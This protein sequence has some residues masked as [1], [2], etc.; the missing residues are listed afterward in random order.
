M[1]NSNVKFLNKEYSIPCD[2]VKYIEFVKF[3]NSISD[4]LNTIFKKEVVKNIEIIEDSD[5]MMNSITEET[6]KFISKLLEYDIYDKTVSD[7]LKSNKG[8]DLFL[9]TKKKALNQIISIRQEKL[10]AYKSGVEDAL[11]R[12]EAS[13]TGLDFGIL[14]NSFANAMLYAFMEASE[15]TKQEKAALKEYN[16]EISELEKGLKS[17]DRQEKDFII[18]NFIPAMQTVFAY[19]AY[20]LLDKFIADLV[21]AGKFEEDALK[22]VDLERSNDLL[23]NL[24]LAQNK[25]GVLEQAFVACPFNAA[26]YMNAMKYD[27]L[28]VDTF[29]TANYFGQSKT[30]ITFLEDNIGNAIYPDE[31]SIDFHCIDLLSK[32]TNQDSKELKRIHTIQFVEEIVDCYD[33]IKNKLNTPQFGEGILSKWD[34]ETISQ[35][36]KIS[37]G[38][39]E[40]Q[41]NAIVSSYIWDKLIDDCGH[42][43]LLRRIS[44]GIP[45]NIEITTKEDVDDYLRKRL[46]ENIEAARNKRIED[47]RLRKEA[48]EAARIRAAEAAELAR[49]KAEEEALA[50]KERKAEYRKQ[51]KESAKKGGKI[52]IIV[53]IVVAAL[54]AAIWGVSKGIAS[55]QLN[56]T[57]ENINYA[58]SILGKDIDEDGKV[59]LSD[60]DYS[61]FTSDV[62]M[63][64]I[65]GTVESGTS[66]V[67]SSLQKID[68]VDWISNKGNESLT[69]VVEK[70]TGIYGSNYV[71]KEYEGYSDQTYMWKD[72]DDFEYICC[73]ADSDNI[74]TIRWTI[75]LEAPV[76]SVE[77][78][79]TS[80]QLSENDEYS[81]SLSKEYVELDFELIHK[82]IDHIDKSA[83][84]FINSN[85]EFADDGDT[86]FQKQGDFLAIY[87]WL[88][89]EYFEG[90]ISSFRFTWIPNNWKNHEKYVVDSLQKYLG[91]DY[92]H[93]EL[94]EDEFYC[95]SW[96]DVTEDGLDIK[97]YIAED[98]GEIII[99]K[100]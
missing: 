83:S 80:Q 69:E 96:D 17:Y 100:R 25:Q 84:D 40:K 77:Q 48:E 88:K 3:T 7:Y 10:N 68:M 31:F 15:E 56:E 60:N 27:L 16:R 28:D 92:R 2:V 65:A 22:Y 52:A 12:K 29:Q 45:A 67:G 19:L 54:G 32:Y 82:Y 87:G 95:Y 73:W 71:V 97:F 9:D 14:T 20:E 34:D 21:K 35:G 6:S 13:V 98:E 51:L 94:L 30:I 43:D 63:F 44:S 39:A 64:G 93:T 81:M 89:M 62:K 41:I 86:Y 8:V 70:L 47:I 55:K 42:D 61:F 4:N 85:Q 50:E 33:D 57:K 18:N 36:D 91:D 23:K 49:K 46:Y 37:K 11:Y 59:N 76:N 38:Q 58:T 5:F 1:V 24:A 26:V 66:E 78:K 72:I 74:I 53:I 90:E 99:R 79:K 75:E